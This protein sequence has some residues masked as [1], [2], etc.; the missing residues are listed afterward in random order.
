MLGR[1]RELSLQKCSAHCSDLA[2]F[3]S[4]RE[5]TGQ[6]KEQILIWKPAGTAW[7]PLCQCP[8]VQGGGMI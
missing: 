5:T 3:L 2:C 1:P 8:C 6:A 4:F 7:H